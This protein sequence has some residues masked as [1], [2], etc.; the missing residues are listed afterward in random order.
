[1]VRQFDYTGRCVLDMDKVVRIFYNI[2]AN[3]ADA[4]KD[5]GTLT[6]RTLKRDNKIVIEFSDT[7]CG[8]PEDIRAR[9]F[10][11]VLH[12]RKAARHRPR[13]GHRE[14]DHGRP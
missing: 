13:A 7:G 9:V 3:A 5:G 11:A 12:S 10:E 14:E 4:M 6:V 8:I 1:M 2:A